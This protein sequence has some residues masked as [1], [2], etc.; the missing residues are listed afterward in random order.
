MRPASGDI[1]APWPRSRRS[2][3]A[4]QSGTWELPVQIPSSLRPV[5]EPRPS[6]WPCGILAGKG[7]CWWGA[8]RMEYKAADGGTG[9]AMAAESGSTAVPDEAE[10][11]ATRPTVTAQQAVEPVLGPSRPRRLGIQR[12]SV[13]G[14]RTLAKAV[15]VGAALLLLGVACAGGIA[16]P[17]IDSNPSSVTSG[18]ASPDATATPDATAS[19]SEAPAPTEIPMPVEIKS[20]LD[21]AELPSF[22][23]QDVLTSEHSNRLNL[24]NKGISAT[25]G[26]P[27]YFQGV[28][29]KVKETVTSDGRR[30]LIAVFGEQGMPSGD[31][32]AVSREW[33]LHYCGRFRRIWLNQHEHHSLY[34]GKRQ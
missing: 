4:R 29:L 2:T 14:V 3:A 12:A 21:G 9:R 32:E 20:F 33:P 5:G 24:M 15:G 1:G 28:L 16:S 30:H 18:P 27:G 34:V 25:E 8:Q 13:P 7:V 10:T 22:R 19:P 11:L 26:Q 31:F 23:F 6:D 17:K